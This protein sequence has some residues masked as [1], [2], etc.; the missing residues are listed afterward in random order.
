M[1]SEGRA[2]TRRR[3]C[4]DAT[5]TSVCSLLI[6]REFIYELPSGVNV[7]DSKRLPGGGACSIPT[8]VLFIRARFSALFVV[9]MEHVEQAQIPWVPIPF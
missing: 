2:T 1:M 8:S 3:R 5:G 4:H 9:E 6:P 7:G